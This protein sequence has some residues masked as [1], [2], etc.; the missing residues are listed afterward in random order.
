MA[1]LSGG[2]V[3]GALAQSQEPSKPTMIPAP[4]PDPNEPPPPPRVKRPSMDANGKAVRYSTGDNPAAKPVPR[5]DEGWV[6]RNEAFNKRI[7]Q[8]AEKGDAGV[9]FIGDSITQGWEGEGKEVWEKY[10]AKRNAVNLGIG[11][12]RTQHV[13]YRLQ[14][15]NLDGLAKPASGS[16]PKLAIVMI[17]TNN[18]N[19][20]TAFNIADGVITVLES[21]HEKLPQTKI[22]VLGIFPRERRPGALRQKNEAVNELIT[23]R[24]DSS[25]A[26]YMDISNEFIGNA[27]DGE[28]PSEIM[29]DALHLSAKGYEIWAKAIEPMVKE[30]LG[31]K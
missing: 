12:D 27:K 11:G 28:I 20:N 21:I 26:V 13:I 19:D 29:P 16:A 15:G 17:G 18:A 5:T 8:A 6:K 31:E 1:F 7:K 4:P 3:A 9:L 24:L 23:H 10:Y 30:L 25:G 2:I 14:N 22:L